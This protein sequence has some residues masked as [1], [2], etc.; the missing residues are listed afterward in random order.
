MGREEEGGGGRV[1]FAYFAAA[2]ESALGPSTCRAGMGNAAG[3]LGTPTGYADSAEDSRDSG[4]WT[5]DF[6][7]VGLAAFNQSNAIRVDNMSQMRAAGGAE[8]EEAAR[9]AAC[10]NMLHSYDYIDYIA[11]ATWRRFSWTLLSQ[12]QVIRLPPPPP[13]LLAACCCSV[14]ERLSARHN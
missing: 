11:M 5:V 7:W 12:L 4:L 14:I 3:R 1:A 10:Y 2:T 8:A 13:L 9:A 6:D